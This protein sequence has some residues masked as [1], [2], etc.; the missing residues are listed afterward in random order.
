MNISELIENKN[1]KADR[2]GMAAISYIFKAF[3]DNERSKYYWPFGKNTGVNWY[4]EWED[5][6][7]KLKDLTIA[8]K[9]LLEAENRYNNTSNTDNITVSQTTSKTIKDFS[10]TLN[11]LANKL[12]ISNSTSKNINNTSNDTYKKFNGIN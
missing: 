6:G 2:F 11:I 8:F 1:I 7:G 3:G 4:S 10:K 12:K 5:D 9:L